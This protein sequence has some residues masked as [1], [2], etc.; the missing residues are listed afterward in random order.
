MTIFEGAVTSNALL[1][2]W[3]GSAV[4]PWPTVNIQR[5]VFRNVQPVTNLVH[6]HGL[7]HGTVRFQE[8]D[9]ESI[10]SQHVS[11][12]GVM[13]I[14]GGT[15]VNLVIVD[16]LFDVSGSWLFVARENT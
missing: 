6:F 2:D 12:G 10:V 4:G 1:V 14:D 8:C 7:K 11:G 13:R 15:D 3:T 16:T 9:F 5:I